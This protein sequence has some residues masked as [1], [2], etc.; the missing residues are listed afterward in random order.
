[1]IRVEALSKYYPRSKGWGL[2]D[3][4]CEIQP[5]RVTG[6]LGANGS[7]KTTF[8]RLLVGLLKPTSGTIE[9]DGKYLTANAHSLASIGYVPQY[10]PAFPGVTGKD[11]VGFVL[12]TQGY[13]GKR[14]DYAR[15][16][17]FERLSIHGL[18]DKRVWDM[19]GGE[20]RMTLLAAALSFKPSLLV[21]DEPS[22]GL[23]PG[24]R[25]LLW[26]ILNEV[27]NDWSPTVLLVTHDVKE[28][29]NIINDV[30]ILQNGKLAS[31]GGIAALRRAHS[32]YMRVTA[33]TSS[34]LNAVDSAWDKKRQTGGRRYSRR[35]S[36]I[37]C[38]RL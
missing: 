28:A 11:L 21:L 24:N 20:S 5:G 37:V 36:L 14:L 4:T 17:V 27:A 16:E 8:A 26:N 9:I 25:R 35:R 33:I 34:K 12:V 6:L 22:T 31:S 38:L 18:R 2:K 13:W 32:A 30:I 19:S 7:G 23:D 3:L 1:M 15:E 10:V 29:E